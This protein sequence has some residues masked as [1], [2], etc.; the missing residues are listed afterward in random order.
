VHEFLSKT[1]T[2]ENTKRLAGKKIP[3]LLK[4]G[5]W[6]RLLH[7]LIPMNAQEMIRIS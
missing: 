6:D 1:Q 4:A 5:S 3:D 2:F 7:G